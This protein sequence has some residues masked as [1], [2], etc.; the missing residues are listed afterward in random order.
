M[1]PTVDLSKS[2]C[3]VLFKDQKGQQK[4]NLR[5]FQVHCKIILHSFRFSLYSLDDILR[6][7]H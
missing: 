6:L 4:V 2:R 3:G 1:W 7:K 5:I